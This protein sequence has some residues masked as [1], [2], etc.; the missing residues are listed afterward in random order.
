M[1]SGMPEYFCSIFPAL[2]MAAIRHGYALLV[3]GSMMRDFDLVAIPWIKSATTPERMLKSLVREIGHG[4]YLH[5]YP[6]KK[7][8]GRIA[9]IIMFKNTANYID[10]SIMS[11]RSK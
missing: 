11:R 8:H 2:K 9:W 3:H 5:P 4:G 6:E 1:K 10:I 7:P